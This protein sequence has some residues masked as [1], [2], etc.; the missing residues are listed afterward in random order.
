MLVFHSRGFLPRISELLENA[1]KILCGQGNTV[2][3]FKPSAL[4]MLSRLFALPLARSLAL[5]KISSQG[6]RFFSSVT[7]KQE[8]LFHIVPLLSMMFSFFLQFLHTDT[9][10]VFSFLKGVPIF[11]C[12]SS[13]KPLAKWSPGCEE[14]KEIW[15]LKF[16]TVSGRCCLFWVRVQLFSADG[17]SEWNEPSCHI[18]QSWNARTGRHQRSFHFCSLPAH[19]HSALC[20]FILV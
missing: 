13:Q 11:S 4:A 5:E 19:V 14:A 12:R 16:W 10:R 2:S 9:S 3:W 15:L 1:C 8:L 17:S 6:F 18:A 7:Q 20:L